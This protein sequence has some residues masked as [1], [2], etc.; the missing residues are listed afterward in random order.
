M[1]LC[2]SA[3]GINRL[4]NHIIHRFGLF[5]YLSTK[6]IK[7]SKI[8]SCSKISEIMLLLFITIVT[9][10]PLPAFDNQAKRVEVMLRRE[11]VHKL[12]GG[13]AAYSELQDCVV[14]DLCNC[15]PKA[16]F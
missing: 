8:G 3:Y 5:E 1:Q 14:S 15:G 11:V 16:L 12:V 9:E 13:L 6:R 10:V 2:A 4:I 7:S